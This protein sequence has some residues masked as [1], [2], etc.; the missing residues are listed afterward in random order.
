M[1]K[2]CWVLQCMA[3]VLGL[4]KA[5]KKL[6]NAPTMDEQRR[7]WDSNALV[8]FVKNGPKFLVWIFTKIVSLVLFNKA[9]LWFG[10]GVPG[11]A[12]VAWERAEAVWVE[13]GRESGGR[14][15]AMAVGWDGGFGSASLDAGLRRKA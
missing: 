13:R 6:A 4:G 7:L 11:A 8:H 12:G 9:V 14:A 1:G 5:V 2:L 10:G 15:H 3:A